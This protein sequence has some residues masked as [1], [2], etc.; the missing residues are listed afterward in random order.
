MGKP[1]S[2]RYS[3]IC[4]IH[5]S[6]IRST[7][8]TELM[9]LDRDSRST[10]YHMGRRPCPLT[11]TTAPFLFTRQRLG[12][13]HELAHCV[14]A[15]TSTR[16]CLVCIH[17]IVNI[18][19]PQWCYRHRHVL[20]ATK[21][22]NFLT[23][24]RQKGKGVGI[25]TWYSV[26]SWNITSEALKYDTWYSFTDPGGMKGWVGL[27]TVVTHTDRQGRNIYLF[28]FIMKI[29]LKVYIKHMTV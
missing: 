7:A 5:E 13:P 12:L 29:V 6:T 8:V 14:I 21:P 24:K 9:N 16:N 10:D 2:G 27:Y 20:G 15:G 26:S 18:D 11:L 17:A 4:T 23:F 1:W 22:Y 19:K 28:L 25:Y 3:L